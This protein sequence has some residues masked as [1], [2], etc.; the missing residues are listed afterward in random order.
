M[1]APKN[2]SN[3]YLDV[4]NDVM[5]DADGKPVHWQTCSPF[6][7]PINRPLTELINNR[8]QRAKGTHSKVDAEEEEKEKDEET[9][10]QLEDETSTSISTLEVA[11]KSESGS[12]RLTSSSDGTSTPEEPTDSNETK[13]VNEANQTNAISSL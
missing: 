7:H 3:P 4:T 12:M 6:D 9:H 10:A 5:F 1:A 11:D 13:I 2:N 8:A